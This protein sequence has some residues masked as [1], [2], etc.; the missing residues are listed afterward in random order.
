MKYPRILSFFFIIGALALLGTNLAGCSPVSTTATALTPGAMCG[1]GFCDNGETS[2]TCPAD[3]TLGSFSG[4]IQSTHISVM[5]IGD[6]AVMIATPKT[7]RY[8]EGA[9]VVVEIPPIF[10]A[11]TSFMTDP[12]LTSLGLIQVSFM[13]PG[14]T[15]S[16]TSSRS[17]GTFDS[18]GEQSTQVLRDVIR[19]ASGNIPDVDG[20]FISS[21]TPITPLTGEVGLYAFG[22]AGITVPNVINLYG[23]Q[24]QNVQFYVGRENP[25]VDTFSCLE[26][27]YL[28]DSGLPV[29]NPFYNYPA[30]YSTSAITLSYTNVRWDATYKDPHTGAVGRA[31]LDLDGNGIVSAGDF[32]TSWRVP[33]IFGKRT[34]SVALTQA[35]LDTG[36]LSLSSW[37]A[38]LATPDEASRDWSF[39]ESTTQYIDIRV[40]LPNL[41]V[42]LVFAQVDHA[43]AAQDKPHIHQAYQGYRFEA[44]LWVRLNP[45]R[46]YV[47]SLIPTA[48]D[49][50]PDNPANTEPADWS[51]VGAYAYPGEGIASSLVPQAAVAEMA[52]RTHFGRWDENLGQVLY[53]YFPTPT[54]P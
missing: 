10:S 3:C 26:A 25:T 52:D 51:Q 38:D 15:D 30:S 39:R 49:E 16:I 6:I 24:I 31:F 13:W 17:T 54:L 45:D 29:Y 11:V 22:D 43:Q 28:D 35:L 40:L 46:A 34:Y 14:E 32:I 41:K 36:S 21:L 8:P 50:F 4:K 48:G 2:L 7:A 1:N 27:G 37:P 18:G 47:Q 33:I 23:D 44:G 9:G 19:F 53:I 12:D 5:G 42:M 20:R